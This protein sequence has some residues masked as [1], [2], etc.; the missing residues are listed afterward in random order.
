V[1]DEIFTVRETILKKNACEIIPDGKGSKCGDNIDYSS[2]KYILRESIL[3]IRNSIYDELPENPGRVDV[4]KIATREKVHS[5]RSH[6]RSHM[7][8]CDPRW[9]P[10]SCRPE[11]RFIISGSK[12]GTIRMWILE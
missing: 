6:I 1:N 8:C 7:C 9:P 11:E 2:S 4:W 10:T 5:L 12:D 3:R